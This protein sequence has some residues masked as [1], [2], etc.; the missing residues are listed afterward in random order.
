M[1][2]FNFPDDIRAFAFTRAVRGKAAG[3]S[4]LGITAFQLLNNRRFGLARSLIEQAVKGEIDRATFFNALR[5]R[6]RKCSTA[7]RAARSVNWTIG[8]IVG[9]VTVMLKNV[10]LIIEH[11]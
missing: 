11:K 5:A 3:N 2:R 8:F 4:V 7:L 10:M 9:L 1:H 6:A